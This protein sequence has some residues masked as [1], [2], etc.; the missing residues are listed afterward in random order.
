MSRFRRIALACAS[1]LAFP[2]TAPAGETGLS[3]GLTLTSDYLFRGV[4]Q[5]LG[6]PALQ[7]AVRYDTAPGFYVAASASNVDFGDG[8]DVRH[9]FDGIVGVARSV[10]AV[11]IDLSH[12]RYVYPGADPGGSFD[13][14]EWLLAADLGER[15][16]ASAGWSDDV[17]AIGRTGTHVHLVYRHPLGEAWALHGAVG[18]YRLPAGLRDYHHAEAGATWTR[19]R[20]EARVTLHHASA[21]ARTNFGEAA[22]RRRIEVAVGTS[23]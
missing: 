22:A 21:A 9:E 4:S 10:G 2:C 3:G 13:Y 18:N 12:A 8:S 23:F 16:T 6:G 11:G 14:S 20:W 17:F 5:T 15:W 7:A 1:A 19:G